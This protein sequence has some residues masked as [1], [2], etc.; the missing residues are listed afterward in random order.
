MLH[1]DAESVIQFGLLLLI[2]IACCTGDFGRCWFSFGARPALLRRERYCAGRAFVQPM[3]YSVICSDYLLIRY[4]SLASLAQA[5]Q[6]S[7]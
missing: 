2:A 3:A 1:G 5:V 7:P 4:F 6:S